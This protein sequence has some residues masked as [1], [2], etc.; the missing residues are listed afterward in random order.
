MMQVYYAHGMLYG[1]LDT[2]VQVA[3]RLQAGIAW[4]LVD[5]GTS[6]STSS[7]AHQ[8]YVGVAGQN[9]NYPAIA[10]TTS[11]MGAMVYTL[12][13]AAYYPSAAYSLVN[14]SGVT[15]AV[16]MAAAGV[17]PQDGFSEYSPLTDAASAPRPRWGDY[18]AALPVGSSIWI[19]TEYIGQRCSFG[20]F[21]NDLTC[22]GTR[23][24]L[25]NWG[26]RI[27]AVTP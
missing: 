9:V 3:G 20:T 26:T 18:S 4:F 10:A 17:G 6:P 12:A 27:A 19:A 16:H 25:I 13:G 7:V 21:Q 23:A 5:P 1:A 8:G 15:G 2:G 22:G 24:P 14:T 11:G